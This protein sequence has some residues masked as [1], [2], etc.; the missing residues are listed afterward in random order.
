MSLVNKIRIYI[1]KN[2]L[3]VRKY[4]WKNFYKVAF[5]TGFAYIIYR[6]SPFANKTKAFFK[7]TPENQIIYEN[8]QPLNY[9]PSIWMPFPSIQMLLHESMEIKEVNFK[10]EYIISDDGGEYSLDWV[11]DDPKEFHKEKNKN[12]ILILHGLTGGSQTIYMRDI[13]YEMKNLKD[14]KICVLHNRG[15]N[16]TP[17]KTPKSFHASFTLDIK[18]VFKLL[19]TRYPECPLYTIGVSM[20]ANILTKYF[21]NEYDMGNYVKCFISLSN[22]FDFHECYKRTKDSL[23]SYLLKINMRSFFEVH[24]ILRNVKGNFNTRFLFIIISLTIILILNK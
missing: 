11:V 6:I 8:L 14:F 18:H 17:L 1:L 10:R 3:I 16:D 2:I 13:L 23:L 12:I 15:I 4:I 19:K 20:G 24:P 21:A 7:K 5:L 9:T 22:P